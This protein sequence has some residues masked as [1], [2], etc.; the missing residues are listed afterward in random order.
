MEMINIVC[1]GGS[2]VVYLEDSK[3]KE[4]SLKGRDDKR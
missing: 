4:Y 3:D 2:G 1:V